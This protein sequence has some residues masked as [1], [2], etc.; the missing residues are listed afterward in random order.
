MIIQIK[1][2]NIAITRID[3]QII[4]TGDSPV[5]MEI[6]GTIPPALTFTKSGDIVTV[7]VVNGSA[8]IPPAM[9]ADWG[10]IRVSRGSLRG[11]SIPVYPETLR[12]GVLPVSPRTSQDQH[13]TIIPVD[14]AFVQGNRVRDPSVH[15]KTSPVR[16]RLGN[17]RETAGGPQ[18]GHE[19][20]I[21]KT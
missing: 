15:E 17:E 7:N 1:I 8:V 10:F 20:I 6:T 9:M 12:G 4:Y 13:M 2:D 11:L 21:S 3:S 14:Y 18:Y 16:N 19:V 5:V